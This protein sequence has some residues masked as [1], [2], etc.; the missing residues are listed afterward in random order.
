MAIL[1]NNSFMSTNSTIGALAAAEKYPEH[2]FDVA[3]GFGIGTFEHESFGGSVTF[4]LKELELLLFS[5]P[6]VVDDDDMLAGDA[7]TDKQCQIRPIMMRGFNI[8]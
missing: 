7:S 4:D 8:V 6:V 5:R 1:Q 3:L 2:T